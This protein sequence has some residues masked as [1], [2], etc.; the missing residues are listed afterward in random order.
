MSIAV[1]GHL[2]DN[3]IAKGDSD[4]VVG[5]SMAVGGLAVLGTLLGFGAAWYA[6]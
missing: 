5:I 1:P 6:G 3:G 2:I 4:V